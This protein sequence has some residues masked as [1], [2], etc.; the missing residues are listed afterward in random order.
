MPAV[1][2]N[3]LKGNYGAAVVMARLS[4]ECLVRPVAADTD[5]GVDLYCETVAQ[6]Q[7]FLHFWVQV[8]AGEQCEVDPESKTATCRFERDQLEYWSRQ[9]VPVFAALVPTDWP[10]QR[11]PDVYVVDIT[12]QMLFDHL[13]YA[14]NSI[15]LCSDYHWPAGNT[16]L[17]RL[18]LTQ[19]VPFTTARLECKKGIVAPSPTLIP[20]Y[21]QI[22]PNVPVTRFM[23]S[24]LEQLRKT[25]AFSVLFV[26]DSKEQT[27][28]EVEFCRLLIRIIEQFPND[29]H[30][31]N[32]M[33]HAL[34]NHADQN[35]ESALIFYQNA[36][37]RIKGDPNVQGDPSWQV[38]LSVI[39]HLEQGAR[40]HVPL[41]QARPNNV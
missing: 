19:A 37:D 23:K 24:I 32:P 17:V 36:K 2:D 4:G 30:W 14:Q 13:P 18:F 40:D 33:A 39:E 31:E 35:F 15:K 34:L 21:S 11:D 12:T 16:D 28:D 22:V 41:Q 10:P 20:Q 29:P 9:P 38:I 1:T 7:P 26:F 8:K 5:V 27:A 25:A 3:R 6:G